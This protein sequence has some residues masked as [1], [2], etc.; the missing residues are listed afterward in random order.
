MC[1]LIHLTTNGLLS[2]YFPPSQVAAGTGP[3]T[4]NVSIHDVFVC[5]GGTPCTF[6]LMNCKPFVFLH[7]RAPPCAPPEVR[8][9]GGAH[10]PPRCPLHLSPC[11]VLVVHVDDVV[12]DILSSLRHIFPPNC[13]RLSPVRLIVCLAVVFLFSPL[14]W[15]QGRDP[16]HST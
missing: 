4:L 16:R 12:A 8:T 3:S 9:L 6:F 13:A 1:E 15:L 2:A 7:A 5:E 14:R 10:G 11:C